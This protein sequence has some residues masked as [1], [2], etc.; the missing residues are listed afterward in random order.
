[1]VQEQLIHKC[2]CFYRERY[3]YFDNE[4]KTHSVSLGPLYEIGYDY[5]Q[6]ILPCI[7]K[8]N[9][10]GRNDQHTLRM[11][12]WKKYKQRCYLPCRTKHTGLDL[13][14]LYR[15]NSAWKAKSGMLD[16]TILFCAWMSITFRAHS[17]GMPDGTLRLIKQRCGSTISVIEDGMTAPKIPLDVRLATLSSSLQTCT[18]PCE[19]VHARSMS[20]PS[21]KNAKQ[22][23]VAFVDPLL[24]WCVL[25][26]CRHVFQ[27][28]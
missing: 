15:V 16:Y 19:L 7:L 17:V 20:G 28:G 6:T 22:L 11:I 1:M 4:L 10:N 24:S 27:I 21:M 2:V 13:L 5:N 23:I 3:T 12:N 9:Q 26:P 14:V 8:D 18:V 25:C